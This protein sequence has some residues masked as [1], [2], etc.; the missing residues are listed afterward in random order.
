MRL[1]AAP[2]KDAGCADGFRRHLAAVLGFVSGLPLWFLW[3]DD[4]ARFFCFDGGMPS[5][6]RFRR[7]MVIFVRSGGRICRRRSRFS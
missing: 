3:D 5:E 7:H 2:H 4:W 6:R 1:E